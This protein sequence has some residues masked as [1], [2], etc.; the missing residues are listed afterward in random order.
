V[1]PDGLVSG[2]RARVEA[3]ARSWEARREALS[4]TTAQRLL[5]AVT[6]IVIVVA[7][8]LSFRSLPDTDDLAWW[9]L[10]LVGLL[11]VPLTVA[12]NGA[13]YVVAGRMVKVPVSAATALRI[14]IYGSAANLLPIPGAAL[15]RI[16]A[17]RREGTGTGRATLTLGAVGLGWL[18]V[19]F[20]LAGALLLPSRPGT[21]GLFLV[22]GLVGLAVTALIVR[23]PEDPAA[24]RRDLAWLV[25]A[26][27]G[28]AVVQAGRLYLCLVALDQQPTAAQAF[29][30]AISVAV[31]SAIGFLPGGLGIR[32]AV[33]ALLAPLVGLPASVGFL[34]TVLDRVVGL[35][36][37]APVAALV[38]FRRNTSDTEE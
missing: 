23:R 25:L 6:V 26:E 1:A 9:P 20:G 21:G 37:L 36:F 31:G 27:V 15:V 5:A 35:V 18:A 14:S 30:L 2:A 10:L 4:G 19:S 34:A 17:L 8:V 7:A 32:E 38:L 3:L 13:E 11:G 22:G 24:S 16:Q 28:F 33:A 29:A 12:L